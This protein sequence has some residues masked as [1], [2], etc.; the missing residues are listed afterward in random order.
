MSN[1]FAAVGSSSLI[2]LRQLNIA[3]LKSLRRRFMQ[4]SGVT[5]GRPQAEVVLPEVIR[6]LRGLSKVA[7]DGHS[8]TLGAWN[9]EFLNRWKA[10]YFL[11][12]YREISLRHHLLAVEEVDEPGLALIAK[13]CNYSYFVSTPNSRGQAVAFLVHERLRILKCVEYAELIGVLGIPDLRPALRIDLL[14]EAT[15]AQF[16]AIVVH[17]KSMR[18]GVQATSIIRYQQLSNLVQSIGDTSEFAL[19][20]GDFNCFLDDT[21]DTSPLIAHGYKLIN[22]WNQAPTHH[23]GGRLDGLFYANLPP[24]FKLGNY[25]VRNFWRNSL[26]GTGFSDH[27]LLTWNLTLSASRD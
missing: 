11:D 27:G 13:A 19:V 12:S 15:G 20:L 25:N 22:R 3:N 24:H 18:G 17:L 4:L 14:D 5:K 9:M 8:L 21:H 2:Q 16:S 6:Q 7:A 26:I 23:F 1:Q 10:A